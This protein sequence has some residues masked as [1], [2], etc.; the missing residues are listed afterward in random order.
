MSD[1]VPP[2]V[3]R[4]SGP[5]NNPPDFGYAGGDPTT[6]MTNNILKGIGRE[7]QHDSTPTG[8]KAPQKKVW[9]SLAGLFGGGNLA[10]IIAYHFPNMPAPVIS[11]YTI[12]L[13]G[14]LSFLASYFTPPE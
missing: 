6:P 13:V 8:S 2:R 9:A 4:V 12:M 5:H 10:I 11:A 7:E 14:L 3:R 1:E